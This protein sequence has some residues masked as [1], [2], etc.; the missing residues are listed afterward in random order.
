MEDTS[1][2]FV[3]LRMPMTKAAVKAM[4]AIQDFTSQLAFADIKKF[5]V[6]GASKVCDVQN[7]STLF[8]CIAGYSRVLFC[9]IFR[10][11][12]LLGQQ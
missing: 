9:M 10:E 3:L 4:D 6:G 5:M 12:G 2:P 11:A 1:D 8:K 7:K